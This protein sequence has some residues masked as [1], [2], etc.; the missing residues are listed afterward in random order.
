MNEKVYRVEDGAMVQCPVYCIHKRG[1]NWLAVIHK[2]P[3]SPGGLGREFV[4]KARGRYYYPVDCLSAGDAVE[5][6]ADYYTGGGRP[7]RERRYGVVKAVGIDSI[8]I[9]FFETGTQAC[10]A[11]PEFRP[12]DP[13][14]E[15]RRKVEQLLEIA[16]DGSVL[17]EK[18][19]AVI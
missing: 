19:R 12:P 15:F 17:A 14:D 8:S 7:N 5:F 3:K 6:G 18:I 11:S 13:E 10:N 1:R 9:V 2:D 16:P 4:P